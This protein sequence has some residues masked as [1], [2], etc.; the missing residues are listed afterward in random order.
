MESMLLDVAGHRRSPATM[1]GYHRGRPPRARVEMAHEGVPLVVMQRQPAGQRDHQHRPRTALADDLRHRRA[2]DDSI[3]RARPG[4]ALVH[5][6][7]SRHLTPGWRG[8]GWRSARRVGPASVL[9]RASGRVAARRTTLEASRRGTVRPVGQLIWALHLRGPRAP[10]ALAR[11]RVSSGARTCSATRR[12]AALTQGMQSFFAWR[13]G[14]GR[15]RRDACDR[16]MKGRGRPRTEFRRSDI[17]RP[18]SCCSFSIDGWAV[19]RE[20]SHPAEKS[21]L[22]VQFGALRAS[23]IRRG[24][25]VRRSARWFIHRSSTS[26]RPTRTAQTRGSRR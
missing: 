2:P 5:G 9:P 3:D 11:S 13:W 23:S 6:G 7:P 10:R 22:H 17:L 18:V 26:A 15:R 24:Y 4:S 1:P 25:A 20:G 21:G 12:L 8:A 14:S 16:A 19:D